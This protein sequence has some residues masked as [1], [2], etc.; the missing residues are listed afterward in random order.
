M[1]EIDHSPEG[2]DADNTRW[3]AFVTLNAPDTPI[4][5]KPL[6]PFTTD[7]TFDNFDD[8]V[9]RAVEIRE[10]PHDSLDVSLDANQSVDVK[11]TKAP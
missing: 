9:E 8:A 6:N 10:D 7:K 1:S 3:T 5:G 11:V 4:H 2:F